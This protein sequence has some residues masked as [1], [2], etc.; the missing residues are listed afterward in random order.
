MVILGREGREN[1]GLRRDAKSELKERK[2]RARGPYLY[3]ELTCFDYRHAVKTALRLWRAESGGRCN[4]YETNFF[5][6]LVS[7]NMTR[8]KHLWHVLSQDQCTARTRRCLVQF[9]WCPIFRPWASSIA[10]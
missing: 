4:R 9:A 3:A 7:G 6:P 1:G 5:W 8:S 10:G 2:I